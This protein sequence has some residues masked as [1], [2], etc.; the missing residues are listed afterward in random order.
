MLQNVLPVIKEIAS[1]YTIK[2]KPGP[3]KKIINIK[4]QQRSKKFTS[5]PTLSMSMF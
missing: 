4:F 2:T 5:N 1:G 3:L